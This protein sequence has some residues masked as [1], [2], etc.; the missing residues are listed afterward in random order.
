VRAIGYEKKEF[1]LQESSIFA[2]YTYKMQKILTIIPITR[3]YEQ[4]VHIVVD[5][6]T[7]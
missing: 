7:Y 1:E 2:E 4:N 6:A 3:N 5:R